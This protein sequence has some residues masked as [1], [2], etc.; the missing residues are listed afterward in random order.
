MQILFVSNAHDAVEFLPIQQLYQLL[1]VNMTTKTKKWGG[2]IACVKNKDVIIYDTIM[3][4][5][6]IRLPHNKEPGYVIQLRNGNI[7]TSAHKTAYMYD[8]HTEGE[9]L[10]KFN[11]QTCIL[12]E[13]CELRNNKLIVESDGALVW[14]MTTNELVKTIKGPAVTSFLQM[15]DGHVVMSG[16]KYID[17]YDPSFTTKLKTIPNN[18]DEHCYA[19]LELSDGIVACCGTTQIDIINVDEG[20]C[21]KGGT[22]KRT[23]TAV[24]LQNGNF[25]TL[26]SVGDLSIWN[27]RGECIN[28]IYDACKLESIEMHKTKMFEVKPGVLA[29]QHNLNTLIFWN[30]STGKREKEINIAEMVIGCFLKP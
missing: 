22:I 3:N 29:C 12:Y 15:R 26:N 9:H 14:D 17:V 13:F 7:V 30:V 27:D 1:R 20:T 24:A 8:I 2:N 10:K 6:I 28:S 11:R 5:E 25:A 21:V 4:R 16:K 19:L 23:I 18:E